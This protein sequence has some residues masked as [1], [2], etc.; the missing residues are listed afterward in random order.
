MALGVVASWA[1][2]LAI[3]NEAGLI[4]AVGVVTIAGMATLLFR[5]W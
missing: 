5:R 4:A 3:V 2:V 1:D